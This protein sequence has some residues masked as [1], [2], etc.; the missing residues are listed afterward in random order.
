MRL[1]W[2]AAAILLSSASSSAYVS[3]DAGALVRVSEQAS[4]S[5]AAP[6]L[7]M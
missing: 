1:T 5:P 7:R 4:G 2:K 3:P 6:T